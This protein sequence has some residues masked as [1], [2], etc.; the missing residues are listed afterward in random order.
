WTEDTEAAG[1][2]SLKIQEPL[3]REEVDL[4]ISVYAGGLWRTH[5][6]E[7]MEEARTTVGRWDE[8]LDRQLAGMGMGRNHGKKEHMVKFVGKK[9]TSRTQKAHR[10]EQ[11]FWAK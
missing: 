10:E 5:I 6:V 1:W 7:D 9:A 11:P 4:S 2:K 3:T 8:E